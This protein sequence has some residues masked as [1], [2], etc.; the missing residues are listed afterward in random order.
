[1]LF[2][3]RLSLALLVA[4]LVGTVE[5]VAAEEG[6]HINT[7]LAIFLGQ[8]KKKNILLSP[9]LPELPARR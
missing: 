4:E 9:H 5:P 8:H 7:A 3:F 1:M 2:R 6:V